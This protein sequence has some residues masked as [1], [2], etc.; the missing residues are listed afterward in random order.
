MAYPGYRASHWATEV[1]QAQYS[2]YMMSLLA[3]AA[4]VWHW[5]LGHEVLTPFL[6]TA[7]VAMLSLGWLGCLCAQLMQL[8]QLAQLVVLLLATAVAQRALENFVHECSYH[9]LL[10]YFSFHSLPSYM[11]T[12]QLPTNIDQ[13]HKLI[14]EIL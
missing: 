6:Y 1:W 11:C 13:A 4:L 5:V 14:A 2:I 12:L 3:A 10:L 8:L 7:T 9:P